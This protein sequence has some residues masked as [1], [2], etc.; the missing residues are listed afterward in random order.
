MLGKTVLIALPLAAGFSF[1]CGTSTLDRADLEQT[2]KERLTEVVG[3]APKSI[4][5]P[6]AIEAKKGTKG[7]CTLTA[8][9]G[10]EIGVTI[11]VTDDDGGFRAVVDDAQR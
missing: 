10:D 7:R 8:P 9:N 2:T 11:H 5:C 1:G 6:D 3:I 4:D